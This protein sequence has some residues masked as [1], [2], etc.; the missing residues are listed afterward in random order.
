[1]AS[2]LEKFL[3]LHVGQAKTPGL[4]AM[5]GLQDVGSSRGVFSAPQ[6]DINGP[7]DPEALAFY[8][9]RM[10]PVYPTMNFPINQEALEAMPQ[11]TNI[12]D[13]RGRVRKGK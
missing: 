2:L 3:D 11:S 8:M 12:E 5:L 1:M 7:I 13:R 4:A 10:G 6:A 9:K